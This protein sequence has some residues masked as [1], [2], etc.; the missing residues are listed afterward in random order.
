MSHFEKKVQ[1]NKIIESQLPEF[2]VADFPKAVEFFKQYYISQESQG[3]NTDL[4][5]NLDKYIK[6]DNLIPEVVTGTATLSADISASDTTITVSS[7]KGY[8]DDYGL[9]KI[10]DEIITYT[11]KTDTSF[12]GCVRGFSGVSGF[13]DT[14]KAYF[15]NTNRQSVIFE[16]TVATAHSANATI[17]NLS[18]LFLQEFYKKLKKTFTPGFEEETFV[19][20]LN[21]SNF[22]KHARNFYQSKGIEESII[23]LFKVLYGVTAKVID[24]ESRLIKASSADYARR[25]VVVAERI[26]GN[27]FG[28]EGQT[29]FKSTDLDTNASVSEVEIFT[30]NNRSFYKLGLFIGYNDRDLIEGSFTIP[31][32]SRVLEEVSPGDSVISVDSTIGF[33]ESGILISGDN[34]ITYTSKSVNQFFGCS[35]VEETINTTDPI[36]SNETVFGYE[37]G[38]VSKKCELRITGVLSSFEALE[39]ISLVESNEKIFVRNIGEVIR[40]PLQN[41]TNKEIFANSW[42]YNTKTRFE[43]ESIVNSSF[44]LYSD[45]DKATLRVGDTVDILIGSSNQV[46][47]GGS[48]ALVQSISTPPVSVG[49]AEVTL[50]NIGSFQPVPFQSYSIRRNL[51]KGKSLTTSIKEGNDVYIANALNV[52]TDDNEEFGYIA[53]NSLPGYEIVDE[54]I[55]SSIPDGQESNLDGYSDELKTW[56][57]IKFSSSVR[58]LT[59]DRVKYVAENQLVGLVSGQYYY[60]K[61]IKSNEIQL[62][63]S[64]ILLNTSSDSPVRFIP[65]GLG[66]KH[67]FILDRHENEQLSSNNILRKIPLNGPVLSKSKDIRNI[68][69]VGILIDGVEIS[70]PDSRDSIYFGPLDKFE[71]LNG[72]RDY[73]VINPPEIEI[74]SGTSTAL[75]EP[76][77]VGS[78][79]EVLVDPQSFDVDNVLSVTLTGGN[80]SGCELR[81]VFGERFR[82][83]L[84]DSRALSLGGGV[85]ITDET[86]TFLDNH[87]FVNGQAVIYNS[88]GNDSISIGDAFDP[89]NTITGTLGNSDQYFVKVI[90]PST[91]KLHTNEGDALAGINTIGFSTATT[92]SGIHK[93]R[94]LSKSNLRKI[95]VLNS[96]SGYTHRKLRVK[97]SGISTVYNTVSFKNHGFETGETVNYSTTGT[98]IVGLTTTNQYQIQKID[99]DSFRLINLGIG[100]TVTTNIVKNKHVTFTDSGSG[101]HIFKYPDIEVTANVSFEGTTGTF[102]F[103][104][105]ITGE[106]VDTY[107]YETGAGYG[108]T[109]INLHKKPSISISKGKNGQLSPIIS[110]GR[111]TDVQI[112]NGGKDYKST[113]ELVVEDTTGSGAILRPVMSGGKITN[114]IVINEGIGYSDSATSIKVKSRGFGAKFDTRVRKLHINDAERFSEFSKNQNE[115][116]FSNLY[117]NDRE[118]SLVYGIFGYSEDLAKNIESLDDLHSPIIGWAYDGNPIYGPYAY[119]DP[120]DIQSGVKIIKPSYELSPSSVEDRPDF[121]NGFFIEDYKYNASGDLDEHNGRFAKTPEYPN[122]VYA[123]FVGVTT[124]TTS[125]TPEAFEPQYP[126]FIG[127]TYRS[128]FIEDNLVLDHNFDFNNSNL[129]RNTFPYNVSRLREDYDFINESYE[130][131]EQINFVKSVSQGTVDKINIVDGGTGY[132]IGDKVNFESEG[133]SGAGLRAQVSELVGAAIT[134]LDTTLESY[135]NVVFEWDNDSQV[136]AYNISG[137]EIINNDTVAIS[138]LSTSVDSLADSFTVGFSTQTVALAATMS[139]YTF[140]PY[141][142]Y[143]D[144]FI[145]KKL[146]NVSIGNSIRIVSNLGSEIVTVLN[147]FDNDVIRVQR[148]GSAGAAH[149][150]SSNLE[151]LNDRIVLPVKTKQFDS[152]R[153]DLVYFNGH[154]SIGVGTTPGGAL[155]TTFL[156]GTTNV[157]ANI[158]FRQIRV[159]NHP[160]KTGQ[161]V[162]LEKSSNPA[163]DQIIVG[164]DE[165][166]TGTFFIPQVISEL[167]VI[168]KGKDYI[169]LTTQVGLTTA[170]NGLF[171]YNN[172]S[173]NSEYKL[174]SDFTQLTGDLNKITTKISCGAT[175]GLENGDTINLT[176]IP[177]TIVGLGTTVA[178]R[179]AFDVDNQLLLINRVGVDSTGI[180]TTSNTITF[181]DHGYKT[182]DKLFYESDEVAEGL[183]AGQSYYV[184]RDTSN[185]FR[186]AE[187]LYETKSSTEKIVNITGVGDSSH[188]FSLINP[189]IDVTKN[190]DLQIKLE[191]SSLAG[192]QLK[193][194]RENE[195]INEYN[196]SSDTLDFNVIGV[197]TP[198]NSGAS[199]T[200][201]HSDNVPPELFYALEKGGY[202]STADRDVTNFSQINYVNSEYTGI[203]DVFGIGSTT[204]NISPT[205]LPRVLTYK[206]DQCDSLKYTVK[207]SDDIT[208]PI[209]K[210]DIISKGFNYE[211]LPE[212][213]DVTSVNGTNANLGAV[214]SSIGRINKV[215]FSNIGYDYPSDKTLRPEADIATIFNIDNLD[216]ITGFNIVNPGSK[217]LNDPDLLLWNDTTNKLVDSSSLKTDA[218][219]GSVSEIEQIAPI[220][221]LESEPHRVVAINNSNGIGIS[222]ITTDNSGTAVC[223]LK[224][225]VLTG[226]ITPPFAGGDLIFVEG[227]EMSDDGD[228]YNSSDYN[229]QFF[230]VIS[231]S[232]TNPATLTFQIA[233]NDGIGFSTNP[234]IA[235]TSQSGYATIINSKDYPDIKVIQDRG[236]FTVNESLLVDV[237]GGYVNTDLTVASVRDD[238]LKINGKFDLEKDHKIKG[239]ISGCI[240]DITNVDRKRAKFNIDYSSKLNIGW[241]NDI[242]K[243]SEDYQVIPD[244]DYYQNLSYSIKSPITWNEFSSPVNSILH[245]AGLKN[246][247]DVGI[248]STVNSSTGIGGSTSS[249][250][251]L[252][253]I[254]EKRVDTINLFD[255]SIDDNPKESSIGDFLQ[256]NS[257]QIQN[258]KLTDYLECKTNR[259]LIHDDIS[260]EFS[261]AGF[262]DIFKEIEEI[263]TIDNHVRYLIQI[264]DPDNGDIQITE[265]VLQSTNL[266]TYLFTKYNTFS[267][268]L[269][270]TFRADVDTFGRKTLIFDPVDPYDTDHDIKILKKTYL[271]QDLP[272]GITGIGTEDLGSINLTSTFTSGIGSVGTATST[273]TIAEFNVNDFNGAFA[274]IEIRDRFGTNVNYIEASIDFDGTD[275]YLNE[276]YFDS[277]NISYSSIQTGILDIEYDS[278]SGIVSLTASNNETSTDVYDV[279]SSIVG[280]GTTTSGIGTYRFLVSGQPEGSEKSARLESTLGEGSGTVRLGTFDI[281]EVASST[282]IVRVSAGQTSSIHQVTIIANDIESEVYVTP[283]PFSA[284]NNTSG[285][286]T[287]GGEINGNDFHLNFYPDSGYNV[288]TQAF[289]EVLYRFSDFDN[290]PQSLEFGPSE[291]NLF[292][293]AFD[294]LNGLRANRVS[295][296]LTYENNPIYTKEFNPADTTK[297]NYETGLFT[298]PNHFFN[299]GEELIYEPKSTFAGVGQTAM[300]IGSTENYLGIVT[301]K[302]PER[303]Y[304]I[305]VTPD[306]FKLATKKEYATAGIF[307]TF[308]DAGEGNAH[309][310]EF[311]KKL[312]KTVIALDGIIQQPI[313]FTP[314]SHSLSFNNGS[315]SAGIATFNLSGISSIQPRDLIRIDDEYM[316]VVEVGLSTN[317]NGQILGPI[318]GIIAAGTAATHP[319]VSVKRGVVGSAAT[320]HTDGSNVQIYRG[321]F[322]IV[323]NE[324]F[325]V[326]PP[327]GN[328]RAQR[329][330]SNL[331]YVKAEFNGRTFLR[332]DYAS[333]FIFDD[334]SDEFTGIGKTFAL[335]VGGAN[336]SGIAPGNGILFINGV[337]QTPTTDNN[338]GNNYEIESDSTSGISTVI[339]TG[340]TSINGSNIES[341]FDI[342][343][344]Q[345]PRGGLV[346]SLGS[347]PGLGYAPLVGAK[348]KANVGAG[349][350][351]TDIVGIDTYVNPVSISTAYYDKF[352]GII[353]IETSDS[354]NLKDG[355]RVQLVGLHFTCTPAYSGVTTTIFP[356]HDRSFDITNIISATELNV[357]VGTSTITHHYVGF[358]SV[359]EHF[360]LNVG[361]GYREPV[362]IAV[363]DLAYEHRFERAVTNAVSGQFTPT[364]AKYTSHTGVLQ[365]TIANHGL[366]TSDTIT[367]ADDSLIFRC[368]DDNFFTEQP[369]PRSTD[370]ASGSTLAITSVTTNTITVNVGPAGGAGTG[371]VVEATVGAGGTLAFNIVNEGSGYINP[372]IQIPEPVYENMP[373]VGVSRLGVGA[374]TETGRNLLLNL[375][376][377]AASTTVGI[378]STLFLIDSY[379]I[380]RNGYAFQPGDVMEVVGLVTAKDY[381]QP[382]APFQLEV[383]RTFNDFFSSWTFGEMDFIDDVAVYQNGTRKRFPLYYNGELLSFEID[384]N[385]PLS[386]EIDLDAVLII[387]VNGVLQKPGYAYQFTGGTSFIFTEAPDTKDNVDIFF[388]LGQDGI[389]VKQV[390]VTETLKIGDDVLVN[391]HPL[392]QQ[393][394]SQLLPRTITEITG[395][396]TIE[397]PIYTGPGINQNIFK[398]FDWIKQ[399]QDKFINGTITYKTRG[400][401]EPRIFPTSKIISDVTSSS[402]EI[403]VDNAQFFDYEDDYYGLNI[404]DFDGIIIDHNEQVPAKLSPVVSAAGSVTSINIV[405]GGNGYTPGI[406]SVSIAPPVGGTGTNVFRPKV[407][408]RGGIIGAGSNTITGINTASIVVGQSLARVFDGSTEIIDNTYNVTS[409]GNATVVLNKSATNTAQLGKIFEFGIYQD[410]VRATANATV[411]AAG[412][413]ASISVTNTGT[414]YTTSTP[415]NAIVGVPTARTELITDFKNIQGFSGIITGISETTGSGGQ[416]AIKFNFRGLL[417]YTTGGELQVAGSILDLQAGYPIMISNTK[418][419]NGVVSVY[420]SD[421]A[422]VGIGTSFLD[423]IYIVDSYSSITSNGEIICNV[424]SSSNLTSIASTGNF[425]D[426]QAGLTT[427]L[428]IIS[429]GRLYNGSSGI[430]RSNPISIGVTGLTVDAGLST[431]PTIQRRADFGESGT[432]AIRSKKTGQNIPSNNTLNFYS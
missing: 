14:T 157:T 25:E 295:F 301:D 410:Q 227:V 320:S 300:G 370:P 344:N 241:K 121:K 360:S 156:V 259:V 16:D 106:I 399:K 71:V 29:I 326:D 256:S 166:G 322:N 137:F 431:F 228:G 117:K 119:S 130:Q 432:G 368:S 6:L 286:G 86:I 146:N 150:L 254:S 356:D 48:N 412:T 68:G 265:L 211:K 332:S 153:D 282:S 58:F 375:T 429:W 340:I 11:G 165:S 226:F 135:E 18:A 120:S 407:T 325:F 91:I 175:H 239:V 143:E 413:V 40:N 39:D 290:K 234:G 385:N 197:G 337:F 170:G 162:I 207:S 269:L 136:S 364:A 213:K 362:S 334:I 74:G 405:D 430:T 220:F 221:G 17:Q 9:L 159:P 111:I 194:Y 225:P 124:D 186:L 152:K 293:S 52:Y 90:N 235:K 122:G 292:L 427:S 192:Y 20:D 376:V 75:V 313:T 126:Y 206:P 236:T 365:L 294:G 161:K 379:K 70:S 264:I 382:I 4:I 310:L 367:I 383:V 45:V 267:E 339:F 237:G 231:Y 177:N 428:G 280:F 388:Y 104:P 76:V 181:N 416:K 139:S 285:L 151:L 179:A 163:V 93:F 321:S 229:Y 168:D 317:F 141:G 47:P 198:G 424:T 23:I 13:D 169:G 2:L 240:A 249:I 331:P 423:N 3:S 315:I 398:P 69:N 199:L 216:T 31:G 140:T 402:T 359:Y 409:I 312:S 242:G 7:T 371:A 114:V 314:I 261:S 230:K 96:G 270:G 99:S 94:T 27:P 377:G 222:S 134:S 415:P 125:S 323:K 263:D 54:I 343:Q 346:V 164:N 274:S 283:G 215:R 188:K 349:G 247:A 72:G 32:F 12:T 1:L 80:G 305:A 251:I 266:N 87:N 260:D 255:N 5:D 22:I 298:H 178:C 191:D 82:E 195:F 354:H 380:A 61:V 316:K 238:F 281:D 113:P 182:G 358:G 73:D 92:A 348:V 374:T 288:K 79:K 401:L 49:I 397:T 41:K 262:K 303:V 204:F 172:G 35:G 8:P 116:I 173:D 378:G 335:T 203:Y 187:T 133:T 145:S 338:A 309:E 306:S 353:Q 244:N 81:P 319:T 387:F 51:V 24:L 33:D 202:I 345:I 386:S 289:N 66:G 84:F 391:E 183:V 369:Y 351:I 307:V 252:D 372:V 275:T 30:K 352:S 417:D 357:N 26:S 63:S 342:N 19:S 110:N 95:V 205:K 200:I 333:N 363:T 185:T 10:G 53:S 233:G 328:T 403:F 355:D 223:T 318:N 404:T 245:P 160:F 219:N 148:H 273:K 420:D 97:T 34:T 390:D 44:Y 57:S 258:K 118:D 171:F 101:Y 212:F 341:T 123:Y 426:N 257:L 394:D 167:Y 176:V 297:L 324:V 248:S 21:V 15:T 214:S 67:S 330:E 108:S 85:D 381:N 64:R 276:Y 88:N 190:S 100:G 347:T 373:V 243:I 132:K 384:E 253:V 304:P 284:V 105:T 50:G 366:T 400:N 411:S 89:T 232:N 138:G 77:I 272:A 419:G 60:V 224:T 103:T 158:P 246:F 62:Y 37:N 107:L 36:R 65:N 55:E 271:Y 102:T 189:Q 311:T 174:S 109:T 350:T 393:T 308:T 142:K 395:S 287:F 408:N 414:G 291:Q 277:E 78:V 193:I 336:T 83:V 38:D 418:V 392:Y 425:D 56:K 396:D 201:K 250:A 28:L 127:N 154:Q 361:S 278:N 218:S 129:V 43:V 389:D 155:E 184:V 147:T 46:A 327:K 299:T 302:L 128:K 42:I 196:S 217:Y 115:K 149:S 406:T 59:G 180:N 421:S 209:S 422:I 296:E 268:K 208:G 279:R 144:I 131:S 329:D 98:E 210:V 112:L